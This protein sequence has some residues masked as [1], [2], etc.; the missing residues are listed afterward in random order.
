MQELTAARLAVEI[1]AVP[2]ASSNAI[3]NP[4][5]VK[6]HYWHIFGGL[7]LPMVCLVADL[8][9][10]QLAS[11]APIGLWSFAGLGMGAL[12]LSAQRIES[13]V[14]RDAIYGILVA[15][16]LGAGLIGIFLAPF[17]VVGVAFGVITFGGIFALSLLGFIPFLTAHAFWRRSRAVRPSRLTWREL[18]PAFIGA[19][20][21][22]LLPALAQWPESRWLHAR[23]IEAASSNPR[24][25]ASGLRRLAEFPLRF[26]ST[27]DA[28]CRAVTASLSGDR[29][30]LRA[31]DDGVLRELE[32]LLGPDPERNCAMRMIWEQD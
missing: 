29:V 19:G 4:P 23:L 30:Q 5:P 22:L 32:R 6:L 18:G 31:R 8:F 24:V 13:T 16:S 21:L 14:V 3:D 7:V 25:A 1:E 9:T 12:V 15:A 27:E 26:R 20:A 2:L 28:I 17:A 10:V 11:G